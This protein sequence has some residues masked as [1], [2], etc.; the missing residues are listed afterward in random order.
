M[1]HV[2]ITGASRGLGAELSRQWPEH[3]ILHIVDRDAPS[4]KILYEELKSKGRQVFAHEADLLSEAELQALVQ[5]L[6]ETIDVLVH[7]AGVVFGGTFESRTLDEHIRTLDL[8]L[9]VP[10]VLTHKLWKRLMASHEPE[11][12][13]ISSASSLIGFPFA[14]SYCASKWGVRGLAE[15]LR[16]ESLELGRPVLTTVYCPSYIQTDL[17]SGAK[18][19]LLFPFLDPKRLAKKILSNRDGRVHFEPLLVK[20][21]PLA[22][23]LL[24]QGLRDKT[25]A[26]LGVRRGM[27]SWRGRS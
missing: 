23:A 9:K 17:F 2:V 18:A 26:M 7:N 1:K 14:S 16:L 25:M 27:M 13:F 11:L 24:P 19:P 21:L 12:L 20:A 15:S 6:P 5:S 22:L 4:L 10:M 3:D 8:N